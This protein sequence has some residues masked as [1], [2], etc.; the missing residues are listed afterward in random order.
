MAALPER[1]PFAPAD[2]LTPDFLLETED[3]LRI[4]YASF[5][6]VNIDARVA[7]IAITPG[8]QQMEIAV[9]TCRRELL[10]GAESAEAS[11]RAK[12]DAS[13]AGSNAAPQSGLDAG[14]A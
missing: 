7:I 14:R 5:D 1:A 2:L 6:A 10:R 11:W 3:V 9:R 13:F 12:T 8:W 4:Y